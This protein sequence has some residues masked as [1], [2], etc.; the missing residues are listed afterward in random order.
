M[1]CPGVTHVSNY[2]IVIWEEKK[3]GNTAKENCPNGPNGG[4]A[5]RTCNDDGTWSEADFSKCR[6]A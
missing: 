5:Y 1:W 2:G 6:T 3:A 4:K